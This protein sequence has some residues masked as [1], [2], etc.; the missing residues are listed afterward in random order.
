MSAELKD[1]EKLD[2]LLREWTV[3]EPA[4][5]GLQERVWSRI[6]RAEARSAP[7]R[8]FSLWDAVSGVFRR[9][10]VAAGY[11]TVLLA[12]GF[13]AGAW[14]ARLD[15]NRVESQLGHRYVQ[16][17]DPALMAHSTP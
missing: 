3:S 13:A 8:W 17:L 4:P 7:P 1:P 6:A 2:G 12:A 5:P 11:V 14:T 10:A 15:T 16:S 9:P